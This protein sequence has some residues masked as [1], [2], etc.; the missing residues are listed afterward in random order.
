MDTGNLVTVSPHGGFIV[1]PIGRLGHWH[2]DPII[3]LNYIILT[4]VLDVD[5]KV[6]MY[7]FLFDLAKD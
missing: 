2:D 4:L 5:Q 3:P 1:L 6:Q 7:A